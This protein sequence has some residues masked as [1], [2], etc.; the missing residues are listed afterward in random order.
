PPGECQTIRL[1]LTDRSP[2]S[3][4]KADGFWAGPFGKSF[5]DVLATRRNEA[6]EFYASVIAAALGS[7]GANVMRQALAGM[8]WSKQF[9]YYDVERWLKERGVSLYKGGKH[10]P[11]NEHWHHMY[12]ADVISMPDK[13]EYPWYAAWDLAFHCLPLTMVDVD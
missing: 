8:L 1:R 7:D 2:M 11:R 5:D 12:N 3:P 4:A 10:A 13:W 9:Y 6:D